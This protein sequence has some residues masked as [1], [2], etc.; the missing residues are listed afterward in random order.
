LTR[1]PAQRLVVLGM[2]AM[3]AG[4]PLFD[5]TGRQAVQAAP[6]SSEDDDGA[7][8]RPERPRMQSLAP[9]SRGGAVPSQRA[10]VDARATFRQRYGNPASRARTSTATLLVAEALL[11]EATDESD[12]AVKWVILDESR[13]LAIS[14][15]S[16]QIIG[17]AVRIAS[18]EFDFDA[19]NVEYRSLLEIPL[20]ALDPG[21]ASEL[22]MAAE[23][24]ATRAE[25]DR[26]FDQALL[27]QGLSIRAWQR[28]GN[29]DGARTAT[30]RLEALERTART[31]RTAK[32][33]PRVP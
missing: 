27:A 2:L 1:F 21:R 3:P 8:S 17:R 15:G 13:K 9:S 4:L 6:P 31:A 12:P 20:R 19:L 26:S 23:G 33:P 32:A 30:K 7:A 10:L 22:A 5:M 18:S 14:A 11:A 25:I 29:I 24:I 28:A 16:P